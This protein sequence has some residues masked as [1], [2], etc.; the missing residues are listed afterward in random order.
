M[1]ERAQE[2]VAGN[3]FDKYRARN[4]LVRRLVSGFLKAFE[5][6]VRRVQFDRALEVGCGEGELTSK[7]AGDHSPSVYALDLS[8]RHVRMT[9][10]AVRGCHGVTATAISLPFQRTAFDLTIACEVLEHLE[11]PAEALREIARVTRGFC[12]LSVPWEPVW[13]GLNMARGA[14][15]THLGNT[16]G[17]LRHWTRRGFLRFIESELEVV[18][19]RRPLPWTIILGRPR[20]MS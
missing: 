17:H 2:F 11:D 13:R 9:K 16:P 10:D 6:L 3:Y 4:P 7:I 15:L 14:Y 8:E 18:E 19:V 5:D 1:S 12:I 20:G